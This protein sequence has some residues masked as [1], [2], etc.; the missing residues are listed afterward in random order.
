MLLQSIVVG[1]LSMTMVFFACEIGQRATNA[2][3][4]IEDEI[5]QLDWYLYP[6]E[7]Q[8]KLVPLL[9]YIQ[10]PVQIEFFGSVSCSRM[11]FKKVKYMIF[12]P[13]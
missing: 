8:R 11:Q 5:I 13:S 10:K 9:I 7:I 2:Y 4:D 1:L 6:I 3:S 12:Q